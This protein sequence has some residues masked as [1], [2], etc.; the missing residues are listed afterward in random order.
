MK[1][2]VILTLCLAMVAPAV[3]KTGNSVSA[4]TFLPAERSL[5]REELFKGHTDYKFIPEGTAFSLKAHCDASASALYRRMNV[6]LTK[7]PILRWSWKIDGI[8]AGLDDVSKEG[9]DYAARVYVV[10]KGAMPWDVNAVDYVWANRQP[11]GKSW[12]NAY[13]K[14]AILVAQE[15]GMPD[16]KDVWVEEVR[17]VRQD[18]KRYFRRDVTRIDGV[19]VMTDCDNGNGKATGNYRD[20]RF[21]PPE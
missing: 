7:T 6:D 18:F 4:G 3:A 19:A 5:W 11:Q 15:S 21:T 17:D 1:A 10:Y 8:H 20:I 12:P 13:T 14:R 2:F 16:D 9:D